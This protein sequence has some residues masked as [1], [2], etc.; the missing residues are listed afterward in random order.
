MARTVAAFSARTP[1]PEMIRQRPAA[2]STIRVIVATPAAALKAPPEVRCGRNQVARR[3]QRRGE[4]HRLR[5]SPGASSAEQWRWPPG[6]LQPN[7]GGPVHRSGRRA[8][9]RTPSHDASADQRESLLDR[10]GQFR[11]GKGSVTRR[12]QGERYPEAV[13][14]ALAR[15]LSRSDHGPSS[16]FNSPHGTPHQRTQAGGRGGESVQ[17][18]LRWLPASRC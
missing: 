4:D 14:A 5:R 3:R 9:R 13:G 16:P 15:P 7:P 8:P 10:E 17:I 2:R 6:S 18:N 1:L 11:R 12:Q